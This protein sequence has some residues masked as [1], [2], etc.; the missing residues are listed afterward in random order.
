MGMGKWKTYTQVKFDLIRRKQNKQTGRV[1][2]RINWHIF[3]MD[4]SRRLLGQA[5]EGG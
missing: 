1:F 5:E 3:E 4:N 2:H